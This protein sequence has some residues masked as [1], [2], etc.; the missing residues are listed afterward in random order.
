MSMFC[1]QCQETAKNSGCTVRGV[2]GKD[3]ITANLQDVLVYSLKG[4][5][6]LARRK[7]EAGHSIAGEGILIMKSLF[8]TITNA[9]FD[10]ERITEHIFEALLHK[11]RLIESYASDVQLS[12]IEAWRAESKEE[13]SA[14]FTEAS[15]QAEA[16]QDIRSL[17]EFIVYG[18]KGLCAYGDHA[19]VLGYEDEELYSELIDILAAT[20]E[21]LSTHELL[22]LLVRTGNACVKA[23]ALL[24]RANTSTYGNPEMTRVNIG[25]RSRPAILISGHD[26]KDMEELLEQTRGTGVDVY[27]HSEMLPAHYY[28][29]FK[30]YDHFAGNYGGSWWKQNSEFASFKGPILMTTNC[31]VPVKDAYRDR[32]FTTGMAGYPGVPH[33]PDRKDGRPKDLS[34]IIELAKKCDPP[35][36]IE[37]GEIVGGFAH[38]QIEQLADR[39]VEA[40]KSGKIKK[41]VVMAGCDGR[42]KS[43][44]YFTEVA[45]ALPKDTVILTAGC[46]KYRYNK[47]PLG[48]IDGIP[49]VLDSGQCNDSYSIAVTA[50]RLKEIFGAEDINDLPV[51]FDVAWY[52]QKA[53]CVLLAL[54]ALGFSG[55]RIGPT[56]PAFVSENVK[57]TLI[58]RFE[59]K[60]ITDVENDVRA[61]VS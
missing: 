54:L 1:F 20:A 49:R 17:K 50:M 12:D 5:A 18:L 24:D 47:L 48:E 11:K 34:K 52:E 19:H 26:L 43:R 45:K 27:T 13:L 40:V 51:D 22:D 44:E 57:K 16:N 36:P 33:I 55:V 4:M 59:L 28:P 21:Q 32:I 8:A 7:H 35:E 3:E 25:V 23:M 29:A 41:F 56:L 37:S 38:Q 14:K 42:M 15:V 31:I 53:V 39:I 61:I 6:L 9:N 60:G 58:E 30:K 2:C 10:P 46:A